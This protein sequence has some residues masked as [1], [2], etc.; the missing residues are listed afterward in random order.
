MQQLPPGLLWGV[1][2]AVGPT[3]LFAPPFTSRPTIWPHTCSLS[4]LSE[5]IGQPSS[6]HSGCL[7]LTANGIFNWAT[8]A[9]SLSC[10]V[11]TLPWIN[12]IVELSMFVQCLS[13]R[14]PENFIYIALNPMME[15]KGPLGLRSPGIATPGFQIK[16]PWSFPALPGLSP[17][18]FACLLHGK[19]NPW[20]TAPAH[21]SK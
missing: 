15:E 16:K 8:H 10:P 19:P 4:N 6:L 2:V 17:E 12:L 20:A 18:P 11:H 13:E 14:E 7:S 5:Q 21:I 9:S 1:E 3:H